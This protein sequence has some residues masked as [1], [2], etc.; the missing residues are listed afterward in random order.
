MA[1]VHGVGQFPRFTLPHCRRP[2]P[3]TLRTPGPPPRRNPLL[4]WPGGLASSTPRSGTSFGRSG[5][6]GWA[7]PAIWRAWFRCLPS[8]K[9]VLSWGLSFS[10]GRSSG[11]WAQT[12]TPTWKR[13]SRQSRRDRTRRPGSPR[14]S[15]RIRSERTGASSS[16]KT[17]AFDARIRRFESFRPNH[18]PRQPLGLAW[19]VGA[20]GFE[21]EPP[22][23]ALRARPPTRRAGGG[24]AG[25]AAP[26]ARTENPFDDYLKR[27][28]VTNDR[29]PRPWPGPVDRRLELVGPSALPPLPPPFPRNYPSPNFSMYRK[30]V[31]GSTSRTR[32]V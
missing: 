19:K 1:A 6:Y 16:G 3:S 10:C 17:R 23:R 2:P 31:R 32:A 9:S 20:E 8:R 29:A 30:M 14:G 4:L 12:M 15:R 26:P 11:P 24:A 25:R 7:R 18:F 27:H 22:A 5:T 13:S 28:A 21:A